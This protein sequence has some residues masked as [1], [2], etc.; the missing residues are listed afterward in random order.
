MKKILY[1]TDFSKNA[2]KAFNFALK[3]AEKH[4]ADLVMLHVFDVL[5][6]FGHPY[7][8]IGP[9][10]MTRQATVNWES[11]LQDFFEK[12]RFEE[13]FEK[14]PFVDR[15][16]EQIHLVV[17]NKNLQTVIYIFIINEPAFQIMLRILLFQF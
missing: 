5:P 9:A 13:F 1:V 17:D 11:Y 4:D 3:I 12:I 10:E 6:V 14:A 2:E 16:G 7:S 8:T 15:E